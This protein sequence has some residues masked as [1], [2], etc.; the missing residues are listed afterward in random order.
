LE[1]ERNLTEVWRLLTVP[2][3]TESSEMRDGKRNRRRR[4]HIDV[5]S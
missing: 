1:G 5:L 3:V 4:F 2:I